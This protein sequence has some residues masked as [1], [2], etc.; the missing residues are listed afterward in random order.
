M[1]A[2]VIDALATA[3]GSDIRHKV[4]KGVATHWSSDPWIGGA[5]AC[6]MPGKASLRK[7]FT[8]DVHERILLA[9]EHVHQTFNA[10]AHGAYETG[11]AAGRRAGQL[12]RQSVDQFDDL[13]LPT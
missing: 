8:Q 3:F 11:L 1:V 2:L 5:Y 6:A 12:L 13:W 7:R 9:G 4:R 10:T